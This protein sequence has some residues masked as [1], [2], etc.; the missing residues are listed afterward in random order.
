MFKKGFK[1][2]IVIWT[3]DENGKRRK[4]KI[5]AEIIDIIGDYYIYLDKF[6]FEKG[7]NLSEL[8]K[9]LVSHRELKQNKENEE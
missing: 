3:N 6:G 9:N 2:L 4:T 7:F 5:T 1:Y 8:I